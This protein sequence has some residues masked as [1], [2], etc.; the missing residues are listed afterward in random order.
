MRAAT[1][2]KLFG[3]SSATD[4]V[5]MMDWTSS[6]TGT[7]S[8]NVSP[9]KGTDDQPSEVMLALMAEK[10][11]KLQDIEKSRQS[12]DQPLTDDTENKHEDSTPKKAKKKGDKAK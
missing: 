2:I 12:V 4:I 11:R 1:L 9:T 3:T 6:T 8:P 7:R 5:Q 10:R